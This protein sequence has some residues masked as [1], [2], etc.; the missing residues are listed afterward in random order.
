M[1]K[2]YSFSNVSGQDFL[3]LYVNEVRGL[4]P[5]LRNQ[6]VKA[7]TWLWWSVSFFTVEKWCTVNCLARYLGV[8]QLILSSFYIWKV[9]HISSCFYGPFLF[10]YFT[11]QVGPPTC[12]NTLF[13]SPTQCVYAPLFFSPPPSMC[14]H[15]I[16]PT[17]VNT[18]LLSSAVYKT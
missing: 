10:C 7:Q 14:K 13:F 9:M 4:S 12:T 18:L 8:L 1:E 16:P 15:F 17:C 2:P 3:D 5:T 11:L 6:R